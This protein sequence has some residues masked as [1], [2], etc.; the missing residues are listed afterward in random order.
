MTKLETSNAAA[1]ASTTSKL[2]PGMAKV[3]VG[4]ELENISRRAA[5]CEEPAV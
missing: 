5:L 4:L 2:R 3:V 1:A